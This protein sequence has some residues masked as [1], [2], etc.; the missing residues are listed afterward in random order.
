MTDNILLPDCRPRVQK[1]SVRAGYMNWVP[2]F[3]ANCGCDGGLVP[4]EGC[5]FAFYLCI[6]CSER[7]PPSA[8]EMR[9]PDE[10][11]WDKVKNEQ[12]EKYGRELT[13]NELV[14]ILKDDNNS[15]TKLCK[16]RKDFN[17]V[18]MS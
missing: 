10:V 1:K 5:N 9:V 17:Q 18:K 14:E 6:P 2:I 4:E 16:D 13:E 3:C 7:I 8:W 11:F 12:L 15:L